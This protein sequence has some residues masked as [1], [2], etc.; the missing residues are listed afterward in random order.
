MCRALFA[1][2]GFAGLGDREFCGLT[3][4]QA[5]LFGCYGFGIDEPL[6]IA[7]AAGLLFF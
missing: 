2:C 6:A 5:A 3:G 4:G 7:G 1:S